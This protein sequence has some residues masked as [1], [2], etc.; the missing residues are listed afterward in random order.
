MA[1][2]TIG[3]DIRPRGVERFGRAFHHEERNNESSEGY[4]PNLFAKV[5]TA[6]AKTGK[7]L[8][9]KGTIDLKINYDM[10]G[11][12]NIDLTATGSVDTQAYLAILAQMASEAGKDPEILLDK[13][14]REKPPG[15]WSGTV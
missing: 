7:D 10:N 4:L 1:L 3:T 8:G 6:Y 13:L 2:S 12:I 9:S 5:I 15:S 11:R 14:G